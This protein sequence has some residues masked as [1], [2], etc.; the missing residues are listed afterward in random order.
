M[1]LER[2]MRVAGGRTAASLALLLKPGPLKC[3]IAGA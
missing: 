3:G 2:P 1:A